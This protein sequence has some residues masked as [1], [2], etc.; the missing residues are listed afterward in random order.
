MSEVVSFTCNVCGRR[1]AVPRAEFGRERESCP[2][3]GSTVR[4]RAVVRALAVC[5]LGESL[6]LPSFPVRPEVRGLGLSDRACYAERLARRLGY[7]NTY[8]HREPRLDI[9]DPPPELSGTL[10]FLLACDVFE[11]VAPPASRAFEGALR[12]LRPGGLLLLTMPYAPGGEP[13]EHFPELHE[14]AVV[15]F[16][17]RPVLLNRTAGG[18][19]QVFDE[20]VFH[21]GAGETLE[22]RTLTRPSVLRLLE[23]AGFVDVAELG[24][25]HPEHGIVWLEP[26]SH[27]FAARRG[28]A[29]P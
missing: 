3:C 26:W 23:E 2:A 12:L 18:E 5:L 13:V 25:D 1:A 22:M 20:L 11:H 10:D 14:H 27:P 19:W 24:E 16:R 7:R 4:D 28:G 17:G 29:R 21:G 9:T 6:T 15:D 8:L